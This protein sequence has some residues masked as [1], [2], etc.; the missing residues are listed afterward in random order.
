VTRGIESAI[1]PAVRE[2]GI[3]ITA[4]G[5]LSRGL[6]TN[7]RIGDAGDFRA[8]L[9]RFTPENWQK[10]RQLVQALAEFAATKNVSSAT[11]ALAWALHKGSDIV[12]LPGA[13]NRKQLEESLAALDVQL[14]A[15]ELAQLESAVSSSEIAGTRY[16]AA[17]MKMLDSEKP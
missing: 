5:V 6:L 7:S 14:S 9:P 1:L 13:R 10:N 12:P 4:Y 17:Q 8:H 3:A 15:E 11:L 2:L 16:D